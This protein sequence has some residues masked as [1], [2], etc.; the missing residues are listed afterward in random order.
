MKLI[1]KIATLGA[2]LVVSAAAFAADPIVGN[3]QMS[4]NGQ[5]KA[6][7]KISEAG[8]KFNGVV[9]TGPNRKSQAIRW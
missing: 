1:T 4:E 3:W 6:V 7:V 9:V 2:G 8:G 5:P